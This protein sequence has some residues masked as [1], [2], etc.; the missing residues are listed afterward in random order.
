MTV[1]IGWRRACAQGYHHHHQNKA[2]L[3]C[4]NETQH[5][6]E[7]KVARRILFEVTQP[8]TTSIIIID[9]TSTTINTVDGVDSSA[10]WNFSSC[11]IVLPRRRFIISILI[12]I[13]IQ[14]TLFSVPVVG[15]DTIDSW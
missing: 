1:K 10:H 11:R 5:G 6:K 15:P 9:P 3:S 2:T 14:N 7:N 4:K 13:I 12:T 8:L